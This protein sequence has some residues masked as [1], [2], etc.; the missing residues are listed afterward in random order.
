MATASAPVHH[1]MCKHV[2]SVL[3]TLECTLPWYIYSAEVPNTDAVSVPLTCCGLCTY[4]MT[5]VPVRSDLLDYSTKSEQSQ[6][7][8]VPVPVPVPLPV[9]V[10]YQYPYQHE[11]PVADLAP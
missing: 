7:Q 5:C 6:Y 1:A 3:E 11:V 2:V 9:Y 10:L 8:S 4:G